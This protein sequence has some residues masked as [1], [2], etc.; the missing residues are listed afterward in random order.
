M[1]TIILFLSI[2]IA[3]GVLLVNVYTSLVDV[4][5]WG[6]DVPNSIA[7]AREYFK[8]VNAGN[9]FRI[10]SPVNQGLGLLVLIL[11]WRSAPSIRLYLGAAFVLYIIA[12][13]LTFG[14]FYPRNAIMFKTASL[15]DIALLKR[16]LSEWKMVN[17]IR[18][19]IVLAGLFFS[20]LSLHKIY[21]LQLL[22]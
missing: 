17:W 12:E 2:S 13:A 19:L 20:F 11:F 7:T 5:S 15:T 6:S 10:F 3:S 22:R 8:T 21:S 1:K 14:F 9:F 16:T 18:S 4:R